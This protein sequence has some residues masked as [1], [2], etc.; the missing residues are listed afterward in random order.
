MTFN[1]ILNDLVTSVD[2]NQ[3]IIE[4]LLNWRGGE[5][6]VGDDNNTQP[7][8][9]VNETTGV[10]TVTQDTADTDGVFKGIYTFALDTACSVLNV[11]S[12]TGHTTPTGFPSARYTDCDNVV[13]DLTNVND[14]DNKQVKRF[15]IYSDG[16]FT[17]EL[18]INAYFEYVS[19]FVTAK[20]DWRPGVHYNNTDGAD[21]IAGIGWQSVQIMTGPSAWAVMIYMKIDFSEVVHVDLIEM[22][23]DFDKGLDTNNCRQM[24]RSRIGGENGN[25]VSEINL[26]GGSANNGQNKALQIA[27]NEMVDNIEIFLR[28]SSDINQSVGWSGSTALH[29]VKI[30]GD[31]IMP[32][33]LA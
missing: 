30:T 20:N 22:I 8:P 1:S 10:W 2:E 5:T 6:L 17:V 12:V 14:L 33:E 11:V 26:R 28:P 23:F 18:K 9:Q 4:Q 21:Y 31:G 16:A 15:E 29:Q 24:I 32:T 19:N 13:H 7:D 25:V 3:A 27:P